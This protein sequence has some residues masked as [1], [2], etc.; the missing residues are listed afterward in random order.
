MEIENYQRLRLHERFPLDNEVNGRSNSEL[1]EAL[2][3][4]EDAQYN[5]CAE[6][7][8]ADEVPAGR[9]QMIR[10]WPDARVFPDTFRD[11]AFYV[12]AA[13][14]S[15]RAALPVMV[16]NDGLG[17]CSPQ[18]PVRATKVLDTLIHTGEIPP[19]AAIFVMPGRVAPSAGD[20]PGQNADPRDQAQ[21][22]FEYDSV[23]PLYGEF[24][25]NEVL[26]FAAAAMD[27]TFTQD[28][29][30][31]AVGGISSGGICAFNTAWHHPSTFTRVLS[32]CGSFVNILGGHHF[33]YLVRSTPKKPMRVFL[34]SGE[35]DGNIILGSWPLANKQVAAAL[36]YAGYDYRFDFGQGG[37]SLRHGG[38]LFAESLRWLWR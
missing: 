7:Y 6:A 36:D 25:I 3:V 22:S 10:D 5:P 17:Y 35:K 8:P 19:L 26:P 9:F 4:P 12:P 21:R 33:P 30:L 1:I 29:S 14:S 28:E 11:V 27:V 13:E 16:F 24:L 23:T 20:V 38:A 32:H 34:T 18:G 37:H 31:R 15:V 2:A